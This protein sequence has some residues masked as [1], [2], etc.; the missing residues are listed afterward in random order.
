M[1][2]VQPASFLDVQRAT[3]LSDR[4]REGLDK[5]CAMIEKVWAQILTTKWTTPLAV[6]LWTTPLAVT[7]EVDNATCGHFRYTSYCCGSSYRGISTARDFGAPERRHQVYLN[8]HTSNV[9]GSLLRTG[10]NCTNIARSVT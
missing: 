9:H 8:H 2:S 6:G 4:A 7:F 1:T 3:L 10:S 5:G